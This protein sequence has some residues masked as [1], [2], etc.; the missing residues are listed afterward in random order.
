MSYVAVIILYFHTKYLIYRLKYQKQQPE[1][2]SNAMST[3]NVM[4]SYLSQTFV[5]V[6][7]YYCIFLFLPIYKS[8]FWF[9]DS[10]IMK[11]EGADFKKLEKWQDSRFLDRNEVCG[12]FSSNNT[13]SAM[14]EV[15]FVPGN[16]S[17]FVTIITCIV[18]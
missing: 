4:N 7:T 17:Y 13:I 10:N 8:Y 2:A 18:L 12:P 1:A 9:F 5:L 6:F 16:D 3:G 11:P 15:G 14:D